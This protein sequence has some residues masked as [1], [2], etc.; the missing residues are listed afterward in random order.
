MVERRKKGGGE[1]FKLADKN[2]AVKVAIRCRPIN[3]KELSQG[4][5]KIV[6]INVTRKEIIVQRPFGSEEPKQFTFDHVYGDG[7]A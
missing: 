3:D 6:N 4:H 7:V 2:E 5:T 1:E